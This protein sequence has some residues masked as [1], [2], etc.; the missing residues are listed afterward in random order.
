MRTS[1]ETARRRG[2]QVTNTYRHW[3]AERRAEAL[4]PLPG[5][6][7]SHHAR[8][9]RV[10]CGACEVTSRDVGARARVRKNL[11]IAATAL[12]ASI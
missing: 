4:E 1:L 10:I 12:D 5:R 2:K 6:A 3:C 11:L 8:I 9:M 7:M